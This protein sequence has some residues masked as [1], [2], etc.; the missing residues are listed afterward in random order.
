[1]KG[2]V[3]ERQAQMIGVYSFD[4][5]KIYRGLPRKKAVKKYK[6]YAG[7]L[8]LGSIV[9]DKNIV[10]EEVLER[11]NFILRP[12]VSNVDRVLIVITLKEPDFDSFLLDSLLAVYDFLNAD[13]L[14]I[15]NKI[16][17][18]DEK[19]KEKLDEIAEVYINSGYTIIKISAEDKNSIKRIRNFLNEGVYVFA[20]PSGV[21]KSTIISGLIG[22]NLNI[23]SVSKKT[24]RGKHTT[25]GVKLYL[26]DKNVFIADTP[27]FSSVDPTLFLKKKE[28]KDYFREFKKYRCKFADCIHL[29]EPGCEVRNGV[30]RG[31]ISKLRYENYVKMLNLF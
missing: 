5:G 19:E 8:V 12:P 7:D 13:P 18:L 20:G 27:G 31:E 29:K 24:K 10:I 25:T 11:K 14:I 1:M 4:D 22:K 26:T 17:L 3:I 9:D 16:D 30:E 28:V 6:V 21:G 23:G 2:I 15:F